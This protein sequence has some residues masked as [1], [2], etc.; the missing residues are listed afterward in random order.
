MKT[1]LRKFWC[2]LVGHRFGF[3]VPGNPQMI[4][5]TTARIEGGIETRHVPGFTRTKTCGRCGFA[6]FH[7][8]FT[9]NRS[10]PAQPALSK[11]LN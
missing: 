10:V 2:W 4:Q 6:E 3:P 9:P 5:V 1:R 8:V 7:V 11:W